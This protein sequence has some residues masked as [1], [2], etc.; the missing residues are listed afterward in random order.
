MRVSTEKKIATANV[1][2]NNEARMSAERPNKMKL[3]FNGSVAH[4]TN[5]QSVQPQIKQIELTNDRKYRSMRPNF[6]ITYC[7]S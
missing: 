1:A 2:W 7:E 3:S 4:Q 6:E 5:I